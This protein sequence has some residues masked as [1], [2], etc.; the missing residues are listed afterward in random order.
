MRLCFPKRDK[1]SKNVL[2]SVFEKVTQLD[3]R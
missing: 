1:I 3:I 2:W